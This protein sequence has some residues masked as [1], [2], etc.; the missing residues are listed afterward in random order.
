[1]KQL[2]N[3]R[4]INWGALYI[5]FVGAINI[6]FGVYFIMLPKI[7]INKYI[8]ITTGSISVISGLVYFFAARQPLKYWKHIFAALSSQLVVS[9]FF[10]AFFMVKEGG[11]IY[12]LLLAFNTVVLYYPIA[13]IIYSGYA[14]TQGLMEQLN[15]MYT[16]RL[17]AEALLIEKNKRENLLDLSNN[18]PTMLV[19]FKTFWLHFLS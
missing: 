14:Y 15:Y 12:A 17:T 9:I 6:A 13:K 7:G 3:K 16:S 19:F 11:L 5:S 10:V 8:L 18:N 4:N 2:I 1:M